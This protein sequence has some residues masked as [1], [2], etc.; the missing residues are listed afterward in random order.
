MAVTLETSLSNLEHLGPKTVRD[1][2]KLGLQT[3][4]DLLF[5]FP[6]R[7]EDFSNLRPVA[8]LKIGEPA[9]IQVQVL[10]IQNR[11]ARRTRR[12]LTEALFRD[13]SG[14]L[15]AVWFNQ[16]YL[17]KL[18]HRGQWVFL[19][20]ALEEG[21]TGATMINPIFESIEAGQE[22]IHTNRLI[23]IYPLAGNLT[24]R[25]LRSLIARHLTMVNSI[26]EWLPQEIRQR[27]HLISLPAALRLIH[28]PTNLSAA[29]QA[30]Q[31]LAFG[32]LFLAGLISARARAEL[33][34]F[35][36]PIIPFDE[37]ATK[38]LVK[39][40]P[41]RLTDDQRRAAW[42]ILRNLG[43][44]R[45]MN[46]LL[47][48]EVGSG[49]TVVAALAILNTAQA[50]YQTVYLAPTEILAHQQTL[51]LSRILA[52][53]HLKIALLTAQTHLWQ[54]KQISRAQLEESIRSG[55]A[56]LIIGTQTLVQDKKLW[57]RLGLVII[58]EQHRFGVEQRKKLRFQSVSTG[59]LPHLLSL[60]AT[61]I[62]RS[63]A[64]TIYGDLDLSWL[65]KLPDNRQPIKTRLVNQQERTMIYDLIREEIKN[66]RQGFVVCPAIEESDTLGIKAATKEH[67]YLSRKIF[68]D[69]KVGLLHGKLKARE[70]NRL[71]ED[72]RQK[73]I[74][75]L[76][77]TAVVEVGIDAPAATVMM[78]ESADRFGL[79]QLHQFRGRIGRGEHPSFCFLLTENENPE[80]KNRLN[81]FAQTADGFA[82][83]E[84]DLELRGPGQFLGRAQS[85]FPNFRFADFRDREIVLAARQEAAGL[86][87]R[88]PEL[89]RHPDLAKRFS[90]LHQKIHLE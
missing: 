13:S 73:K 5:H 1:L 87:A 79:A 51:A 71:I 16:P 32:E 61:P 45:S 44:A 3:I 83:A 17:P 28:F 55:Q 21:P 84:R 56:N 6:F 4:R 15:K 80:T 52:K 42:Q 12:F 78:I 33:E 53:F 26:P 40:L 31:R 72:F 37:D 59:P 30:R 7:Y 20:G 69:L 86:L 29:D 54:G 35:Q 89:T 57:P 39:N 34:Q 22:P 41:F 24:S 76:V 60:T 48:G 74:D 81:F 46:R 47:Q 50:G 25:Q 11:R 90:K 88:D 77:S 85:G 62:P 66:S 19:S 65:R 68:P 75:L 49:K 43:R 23:P 63:L 9:S 38:I 67:E 58:D 18:L 8:K 64:L 82:L 70:K 27:R 36:A 10:L 2:T 14:S